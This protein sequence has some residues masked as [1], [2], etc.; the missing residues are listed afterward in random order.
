MQSSSQTTENPLETAETKKKS[1][2]KKQGLSSP[3]IDI[4]LLA[5]AVEKISQGEI[6]EKLSVETEGIHK[7][8]CVH[9][10]KIID[11]MIGLRQA[12]DILQRIKVNHFEGKVEGEFQGIFGEAIEGVNTIGANLADLTE[13]ISS[14]SNGALARMNHC[15]DIGGGRGKQSD[16]DMLTPAMIRIMENMITNT[17][18]ANAIAAGDLDVEITPF[19]ENDFLSKAMILIRN[20]MEAVIKVTSDMTR[21]TIEGRLGKRIAARRIPGKWGVLAKRINAAMDALVTHIDSIPLPM[22]IVDKERKI[23]FANR[24]AIK[25]VGRDQESLLNGHCHDFY[26]GSVCNTTECPVH[27][28]IENNR[29]SSAEMSVS[30]GDEDYSI[31]STGVPIQD[32]RGEIVGALQFFLD[33]TVQKSVQTRVIQCADQLLELM[34]GLKAAV[35][36]MNSDTV[37]VADQT[38]QIAAAAEELSATMNSIS[39]SSHISKDAITGIAASTEELSATVNEIAQTADRARAVAEDAVMNVETASKQVESLDSAAKDIGNVIE[40]ILA[41]ADQTKLL[42]LNATIEAA[43]AGEAGKG[44]SV[45]AREVKE[46]AKQTNTSVSEI[47]IKIEAIQN[48]SAETIHDIQNI[49]NVM[50]EVSTFVGSIAAATEQQS[51]A[52]RGI[53]QNIVQTIDAVSESSDAVS[54]TAQV[55]Q[56]MTR[57]ISQANDRFSTIRESTKKVGDI[58]LALQNTARELTETVSRFD[59]TQQAETQ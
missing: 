13:T 23:Q 34:S 16:E 45:V 6:P 46:L 36:S 58:G 33:Q 52:T 26:K 27:Q 1:P 51:A 37:D 2:S 12:S 30:I 20:Q 8:T 24:A 47:R 53:S 55:T 41:I 39:K 29:I 31:V 49:A 3:D 25:T 59:S 50:S 17:N 43:R 48:A 4:A 15:K 22:M 56:D 28:A 44:F 11:Q 19:S 54:Q 7:A 21:H 35:I 9:I 32:N 5:A 57:S 38:C 14:I 40:L 42:A 10:N 18:I